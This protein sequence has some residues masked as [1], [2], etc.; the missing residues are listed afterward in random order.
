M[1]RNG[2]LLTGLFAT[3]MIVLCSSEVKA[4]QNAVRENDKER[5]ALSMKEAHAV[6]IA[7]NGFFERGYKAEEFSETVIEEFSDRI[8][9]V[10]FRNKTDLGLLGSPPQFPDWEFYVDVVVGKVIVVHQAM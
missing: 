6:Q 5:V 10:T 2:M 1:C 4:Q 9:R 3:L 8:F 7:F